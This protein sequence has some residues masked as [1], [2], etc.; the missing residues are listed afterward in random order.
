MEEVVWVSCTGI[1]KVITVKGGGWR[2]FLRN[3][4]SLVLKS[5][6]QIFHVFSDDRGEC[7]RNEVIP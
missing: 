5:L 2:V 6:F 4:F 3:C 7:F 1:R